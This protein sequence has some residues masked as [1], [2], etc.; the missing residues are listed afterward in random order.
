MGIDWSKAAKLMAVKD[1]N[2]EEPK[3]SKY[4]KSLEYLYR[5]K[6]S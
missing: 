4:L 3:F 1:I 6:Q 5:K 2:I